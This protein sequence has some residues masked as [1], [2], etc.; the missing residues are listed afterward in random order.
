MYFFSPLIPF[1]GTWAVFVRALS[2]NDP[3][4]ADGNRGKMENIFKETETL[5]MTSSSRR[6]LKAMFRGA[7]KETRKIRRRS[8]KVGNYFCS[9]SCD[10][11]KN[12][13]QIR[14]FFRERARPMPTKRVKSGMRTDTLK[15]LH[16]II[17]S[18][19]LEHWGKS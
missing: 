6:L 19:F 14:N 2:G 10:G 8:E 13:R 16:M 5:Q 1:L 15:S 7:G 9:L 11:E 18:S 4:D 17:L 12:I 3:F